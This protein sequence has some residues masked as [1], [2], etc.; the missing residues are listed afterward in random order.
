MSSRTS[1]ATEQDPVSK[2]TLGRAERE[3][4][5]KLCR[6]AFMLMSFRNQSPP[7][8]SC[9]PCPYLKA[10]S[11]YPCSQIKASWTVHRGFTMCLPQISIFNSTC[12]LRSLAVLRSGI[13]LMAYPLLV[14]SCPEPCSIMSSMASLWH[15]CPLFSSYLLNACD[16]ASLVQTLG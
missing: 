13:L 5:N 4:T 3:R 6:S 12:P 15:A 7:C 14:S 1:W 9:G 2:T 8:V 16:V 11:C 10:L